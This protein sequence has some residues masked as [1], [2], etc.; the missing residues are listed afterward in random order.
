MVV[1]VQGRTRS[2]SYSVEE[3][4]CDGSEQLWQVTRLRTE[5]EHWVHRHGLYFG[6]DCPDFIFRRDGIDP[7]G[8]LHIQ[9]VKALLGY[10]AIHYDHHI[11]IVEQGNVLRSYDPCGLGHEAAVG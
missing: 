10:P 4:E 6:C 3:V 1:Y 9:A 2:G 8:C 11:D 7:R 5:D